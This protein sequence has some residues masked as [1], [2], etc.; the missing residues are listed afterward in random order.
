MRIACFGDVHGDIKNLKLLYS[1]LE[2]ES[3]DAIYHLGDLV[4][5]GPDPAGVIGFCI[6]KH[7]KGVAGNHDEALLR[8][9]ILTKTPPI[10]KDKLRSYNAIVS[11]H[12]ATEYLQSL[13]KIV[14]LEQLKSL[15]VHA[16][17]NP[18]KSLEEQNS[19]CCYV[20][21]VN[22]DFPGLSRWSGIDRKGIPEQENRINGWR[23]WYELYSLPYH[24]YHGH[25]VVKDPSAT[26]F[27]LQKSYNRVAL[28]TGSWFTGMLS[29]AIID[30]N[31]IKK[32][33][34]TPRVRLGQYRE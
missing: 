7:I 3:L 25:T 33:I 11:T 18:L 19:M 12:G 28:D 13:P 16:G 34:S 22:P 24:V 15:L 30:T 4:D 5:R 2:H 17:I 31:G 6:E 1:M 21:M 10:N 9:H 26:P 32:F 8:K 14:V 27:V 23:R 29:A 20:S